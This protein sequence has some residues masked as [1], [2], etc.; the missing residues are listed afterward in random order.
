MDWRVSPCALLQTLLFCWVGFA[1]AEWRLALGLFGR[2]GNRRGS[3]RY[4]PSD[5]S[6]LLEAH[7]SIRRHIIEAN[8]RRGW[9]VQVFAHSPDVQLREDVTRLYRP[10][11]ANFT[12]DVLPVRLSTSTGG[13]R[14]NEVKARA[15]A[16]SVHGVVQLLQAEERAAG[17]SFDAVILLRLDLFLYRDL[18]VPDQAHLLEGI[19]VGAWCE[20]RSLD[21]ML[22]GSSLRGRRCGRLHAH[23]LYNIGMP[24]CIFIGTSSNMA[25]LGDW[26]PKIDDNVRRLGALHGHEDAMLMV[27]GGGHTLIRIQLNFNSVKVRYLH[28]FVEGLDYT[29]ARRRACPFEL[30][31]KGERDNVGL[32]CGTLTLNGRC[33]EA[34]VF[35]PLAMSVC[36]HEG[37]TVCAP[38]VPTNLGRNCS[39]RRE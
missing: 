14:L 30:N 34:L 10:A 24:D 13:R 3:S 11:R 37:L 31:W 17:R 29:V 12:E 1:G 21:S 5:S 38:A 27:T 36:P 33:R 16:V 35:D 8:E 7:D 15:F 39:L 4:Y 25:I 6:I 32:A 22:M 9:R 18:L 23:A 19:W 20:P 2:A 28:S 26:G